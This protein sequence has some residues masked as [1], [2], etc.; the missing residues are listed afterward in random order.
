MVRLVG[1]LVQF[2]LMVKRFAGKG[3]LSKIAPGA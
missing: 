3:E 1:R 2:A